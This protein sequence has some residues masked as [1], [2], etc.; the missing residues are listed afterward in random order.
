MKY[1][2]AMSGGVDSS[3]AA[4]LLKENGHDFAGCYMV[5]NEYITEDGEKD[6]RLVAKKLGSELKVCG[7]RNEFNTHVM[8]YFVQ[9]YLNGNTPNPCVECNRHIKF[10]ALLEYALQNGFDKL[11]TG[12]YAKVEEKDNRFLLRKASDLTKDQ[13]Y[14]LYG[15]SQEQL[16]KIAFPLGE[17]TKDEIRM[18]AEKNGFVNAHKKDSQDICFVPEGKYNAVIEKYADRLPVPGNFTDKEGKILG[19]HKGIYN[20]TYGQR[21]G[22]GISAD[23]PLYVTNIDVETNTVV[24]GDNTDLFVREVIANDVNWIADRQNEASF[25]AKARLRY[26]HKEQPAEIIILDKNSIKIV[27]DEPQRAATRGQSAVVYDGEYVVCGGVIQ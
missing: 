27:F 12:H 7:F 8:S 2:M 14:F 26:C 15:L 10:G 21:K 13:S 4:F 9:S 22:L 19:K 25:R 3:V 1:L 20:Y 23:R 24:L 5:L 6:A 16:S 18:I 11:A 17:Y